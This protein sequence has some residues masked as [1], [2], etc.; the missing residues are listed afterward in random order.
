MEV[1]K[2]IDFYKNLKNNPKFDHVNFNPTYTD[3]EELYFDKI[4]EKERYLGKLYKKEDISKVTY[5]SYY[6]TKI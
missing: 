1:N 5:E 4:I 2:K 3:E 6:H